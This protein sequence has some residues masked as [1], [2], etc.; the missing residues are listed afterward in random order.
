MPSCSSMLG[1]KEVCDGGNAA[2]LGFSGLL[3]LAKVPFVVPFWYCG[4]DDDCDSGMTSRCSS[5]MSI[6]QIRTVWSALQVAR[7][8]MSGERRRRVR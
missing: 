1:R 5:F 4:W 2:A 7:S 8:F 3:A 6:F